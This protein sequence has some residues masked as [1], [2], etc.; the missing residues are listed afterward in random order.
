MKKKILI[1]VSHLN[2]GGAQRFIVNFANDLKDQ[3]DIQIIGLHQ[4]T[5]PN[6]LNDLDDEIS[7]HVLNKRALKSAGAISK[8]IKEFKPDVIFSTQSYV[9]SMTI[10][11]SLFSGHS[12]RI[13]IREASIISNR[14]NFIYWVAKLLYRKADKIIAQTSIIQNEIIEHF[15]CSHQKVSVLPNYINPKNLEEKANQNLDLN[16]HQ[17]NKFKF[18]FCGRLEKVKNVDTLIHNLE[19]NYKQRKNFEFWIIGDGSERQNLEQYCKDKNLSFV[20][21]LGFQ[22][23]PY[24]Y[25]KA[26]DCL[27][28]ASY[29]EGFPNVVVEAM[30][31][32]CIILTNDFKGGAANDILDNPLSSYIYNNKNEF[33]QQTEKLLALSS[34]ELAD[35]KKKFKSRSC[36]YN[37][38]KIIEKY[39][40]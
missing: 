18:I 28:M 7:Y 30:H 34:A 9:N 16:K 4:S 3:Y 40:K 21:F 27:L 36:V 17:N 5:T 24:P 38:E 31:L 1:I 6:F 10:L 14:K 25:M 33:E 26:A 20:R 39:L 12:C 22:K 23:N 11:A 29:R 19:Y 35:L 2:I 32:D 37:K 13:I 8:I 15:G